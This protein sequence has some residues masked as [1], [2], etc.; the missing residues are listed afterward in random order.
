MNACI[1]H[2]IQQVHTISMELEKSMPT[3][4]KDDNIWDKFR[5][6]KNEHFI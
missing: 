1:S 3:L 4:G 5:F 2:I 6:H